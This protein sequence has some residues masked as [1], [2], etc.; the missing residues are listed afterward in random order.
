MSDTPRTDA[1]S[2]GL[3]LDMEIAYSKM[4]D[5]ARQ[6]ERELAEAQETISRLRAKL[7]DGGYEN[8]R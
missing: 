8:W 3:G 7:P 5:L 4:Q 1:L 2:S 6:L